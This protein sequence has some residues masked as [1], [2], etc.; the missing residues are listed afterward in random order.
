[1]RQTER[2]PNLKVDMPKINT[3]SIFSFFAEV[4]DEKYG[5][6]CLSKD[7]SVVIFFEI[8]ALNGF[9]ID[10]ILMF[11]PKYSS[12]QIYKIHRG[13]GENR[14][15][16]CIRVFLDYFGLFL[17]NN[18]KKSVKQFFESIFWDVNKAIGLVNT[19]TVEVLES[20]VPLIGEV[21]YL[22]PYRELSGVHSGLGGCVLGE[23][24][25]VLDDNITS[26]LSQL[27]F[28]DGSNCEL[29]SVC[30]LNKIKGCGI[31]KEYDYLQ[32]F[33]VC[34]PDKENEVKLG[35]YLSRFVNLFDVVDDESIDIDLGIETV[36]VDYQIPRLCF[37]NN[38]FLVRDGAA[39]DV[40]KKLQAAG[41]MTYLHTTSSILQY[42]SMFP[43]NVE[44]GYLF[45]INKCDYLLGLIGDF[46]D[47]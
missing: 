40:Q 19:R 27:Q 1:M 21:E 23:H 14:F 31:L 20:V 34:T 13:S 26:D 44:Y 17:I 45:S 35:K 9:D 30:D 16:A 46:F 33:S 37:F 10:K 4:T 12:V 5:K 3:S 28:S 7:G 2:F 29:F 42:A 32:Y 22:S 6:V 11:L 39:S 43:A 25:L 24:G 47:L 38:A 15:F 8:I 41:I 18:G 36:H